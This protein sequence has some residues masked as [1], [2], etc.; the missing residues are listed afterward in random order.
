MVSYG[1]EVSKP[2]VRRALKRY[3]IT[4][5]KLRLK[6]GKKMVTSDEV[7]LLAYE[8]LLQVR[9]SGYFL[10]TVHSID[11]TYT[12]H[13]RDERT[14]LGVIGAA[15]PRGQQKPPSIYQL[16]RDLRKSLRKWVV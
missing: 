13:R 15:Q 14:G 9:A 12:S 5:R 3:G 10:G 2:T 8:F 4:L 1:L 11:S 16:Y 7:Q 6:K